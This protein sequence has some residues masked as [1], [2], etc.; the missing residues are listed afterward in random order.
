LLPQGPR[1]RAA[2]SSSTRMVVI[3]VPSPT[4]A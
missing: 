4:L 1:R 3:F 2:N